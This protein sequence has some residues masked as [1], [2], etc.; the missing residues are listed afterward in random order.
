M[1]I[2]SFRA[3]SAVE[4]IFLGYHRA[5]ADF[6]RCA[7]AAIFRLLGDRCL[8]LFETYKTK[9]QSYTHAKLRLKRADYWRVFV[10][11]ELL[12]LRAHVIDERGANASKPAQVELVAPIAALCFRHADDV[13]DARKR[14]Q[15]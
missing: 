5:T 1:K 15:A 10:V 9:N 11:F 6:S 3:A 8:Q 12:E 2:F 4:I 7:A 13:R 14:R